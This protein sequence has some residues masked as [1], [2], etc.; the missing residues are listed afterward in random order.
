MKTKI[1][2][3]L[4]VLLI[5][6][7]VFADG[8]Y[9]PDYS[10]QLFEPDQ[11][12]VIYW[13]GA[14]E[15][16]VLSSAVQAEDIVNV[17]WVVPI[18]SSQKPE[19]TE[20]DTTLF[21]RMAG[22]FH[23][24]SIFFG[25]EGALESTGVEV[26]ESKEIDIYDITI[27]KATSAKDL[28]GWLNDNG[29]VVGEEA[30]PTLQWYADQENFYF[31]ANRID[32]SNK[33][34]D[35]VEKINAGELPAEE[36]DLWNDKRWENVTH[37]SEAYESIRLYFADKRSLAKGMATPLKFEF[38]PEQP[39]YP[40]KISSIHTGNTNINV[41]VVAKYAVTDTNSIM[42]P[43]ATKRVFPSLRQD[44]KE[45]VGA[46]RAVLYVTRLNYMD[47]I[48]LLHNDA[49]FVK[50]S[51]SEGLWEY[52]KYWMAELFADKNY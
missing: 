41:Y 8:G 46:E 35:V 5:V 40:L 3:M 7:I 34:K 1:L 42:D 50:T 6:P 26:I 22:Y 16:M 12:A 23:P 45:W 15:T 49:V 25:K 18:Q 27:L 21:Y 32:L 47:E 51:Y 38:W 14:K 10:M 19:V 4:M 20:G 52:F 44:L 13:D 9:F 31:I 29:Y 30:E 36:T 24:P 28:I 33:H 43:V 48:S 2:V 39:Y 11:K 17:A 37:D